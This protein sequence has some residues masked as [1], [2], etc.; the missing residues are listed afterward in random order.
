M[1]ARETQPPGDLTPIPLHWDRL[2]MHPDGSQDDHTIVCCA[3]DNGQPAALFLDDEHR[4]AL[5]LQLLLPDGDGELVDRDA[6]R[7]EVLREAADVIGNDDT[8]ECGGCD[9]CIPRKLA[10]ELRRLADE[11]GAS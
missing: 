9:T 5:G 3:T 7:A 6:H 1:N 2:V 11:G 10:A 8:C 4:E